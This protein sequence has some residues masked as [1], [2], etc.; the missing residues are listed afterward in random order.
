MQLFALV[1]L[2]A[3]SDELVGRSLEVKFVFL[4][5]DSD[6]LYNNVKNDDIFMSF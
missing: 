1:F 5:T 6:F 3:K 2:T 4:L